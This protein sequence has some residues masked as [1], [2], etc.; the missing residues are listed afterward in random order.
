MPEVR[1]ETTV[2]V[3][4]YV[5]VDI[6][7]ILDDCSEG[8]IQN[9]INWLKNNNYLVNEQIVQPHDLSYSEEQ[10]Y[11]KLDKLSKLYFTI[12]SEDLEIL[13]ELLKKY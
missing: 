12:S 1:V 3:D 9:T 11:A 8:E 13:E 5:D 4:E 6:E 2:D 10:F 7:N